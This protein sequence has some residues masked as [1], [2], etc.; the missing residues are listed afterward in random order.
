MVERLHDGHFIYKGPMNQGAPGDMGR[1][2][3][4]RVGGV[5]VVLNENR[6]QNF[7]P[8]IF[9]CLGIE[10]TEQK[11]VVVKSV[12]HFRAA[13]GPWPAWSWR[14]TARASAPSTSLAFPISTS[15]DR[16]TALTRS[17]LRR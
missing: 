2:V 8:E 7:D 12:V 6:L 10:P 14:R 13:Y 1:A 5:R 16:C 3:V 9:R 4:L 11:L 15:R 17:R